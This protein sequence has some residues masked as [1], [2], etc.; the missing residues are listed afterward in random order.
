MSQG[1]LYSYGVGLVGGEAAAPG[2]GGGWSPVRDRVQGRARETWLLGSNM[3]VVQPRLRCRDLVLWSLLARYARVPADP[4]MATVPHPT[5][6]PNQTAASHGPPRAPHTHQLARLLELLQALAAGHRHGGSE[7]RGW[8]SSTSAG[9]ARRRPTARP[10]G[11]GSCG[12]LRG[13]VLVSCPCIGQERAA[14]RQLPLAKGNR[15]GS[16]PGECV[17]VKKPTAVQP[18]EG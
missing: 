6:I 18:Q 17:G 9:W 14:Q 12:R 15:G 7:G 10:L 8:S 5:P 4:G 16:P 13:G 2:V 11:P 3:R 1:S